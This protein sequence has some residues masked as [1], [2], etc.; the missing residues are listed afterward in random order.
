[1]SHWQSAPAA[2]ETRLLNRARH[3]AGHTRW[4]QATTT[5]DTVLV[6]TGLPLSI[7][8]VWMV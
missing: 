6:R 2:L 5:I 1:M 8:V 4:Y 7:A 3:C